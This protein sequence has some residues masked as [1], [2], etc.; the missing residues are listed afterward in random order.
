MSS[1]TKA[2]DQQ[3]ISRHSMSAWN[4]NTQMTTVLGIIADVL[5]MLAYIFTIRV[6]FRDHSYGIPLVAVCLNFTWEF[7]FSLVFRP[8]SKLRM[9]LTL[10]WL[11]IDSVIL[12]QLFRWGAGDQVLWI[13][14]HFVAVVIG[15][16]VLAAIGHITFNYTYQEHGGQE[17]AFIINLVMSILFVFLFFDRPGLRGL[18]YAAAWLKMIG[19]LIL[20]LG[21]FALMYKE[22]KKYC[23]FFFL[24]A[25]I[26]LFD[27]LYVYLM[28]QARG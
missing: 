15:T 3:I 27:V 9:V 13:R 1:T 10:L 7:I 21:N 8:K 24:F 22:P 20:S 2:V 12:Y 28:T 11:A 4:V 26:F 5:W 16:L 17:G 14:A 25:T 19:T 18:S 6:G 23:F